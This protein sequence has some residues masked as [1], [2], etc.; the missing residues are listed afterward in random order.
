MNGRLIHIGQVILDLVMRVPA[1]PTS[2]HDV[3]A[4]TTDLTPGGGINVMAAAARSGADVL[5]AGT[6]GTGP[7][8]DRVRAALQAEGIATAQPPTDE[9]G[10][11]ICVALIEENGERT[12]VTG[13]GAGGRLH[14]DNVQVN[15]TDLIYVTGYT[16]LDP[17]NQLALQTWLAALPPVQV[18]LDPG[19]LAAD[20]PL[21]DLL[22]Y[23]TILSCNT[24]E[25]KALHL[26]TTATVIIRTGASGCTITHAGRTRHI[27]GYPVTPVDTNGA[28]DT[29]C[30]VLAAELLRGTDLETAARRANAAAALSVLHQG[31]ATAPTRQQITDFLAAP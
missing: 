27:P 21:D 7:F 25:A 4:T 16:L 1:L 28:G 8:G 11:G 26:P 19:P 3:L 23:V 29:H 13:T 18:L 24:T 5:Y 2:G 31:P 10:T 17:A 6:H 9:S 30:G 20:L 22:K 14:L 15:E 12:F